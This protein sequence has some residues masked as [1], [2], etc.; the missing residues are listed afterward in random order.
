MP[1]APKELGPTGKRLAANLKALRRARGL[2]LKALSARLDQLGQPIALNG[3]SKIELGDR[4]VDADDLVAL[5]AALDVS[6]AR[7]LLP[8]QAATEKIGI[9]PAAQASSATAWHWA[10]GDEPLPRQ[11]WDDDAVTIDVDRLLR[12]ARENRPHDPLDDMPMRE[13]ERRRDVLVPV[14][15]AVEAARSEGL[16]LATIFGWVR[17]MLSIRDALNDAPRVGG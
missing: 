13:V 2:D 12:F 15:V 16:T 3:L 8:E 4:R 11:P 7:L 1:N 17:M 14:I 6:P 5:A 9:T 10:T